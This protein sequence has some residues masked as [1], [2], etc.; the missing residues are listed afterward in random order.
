MGVVQVTGTE[1]K[2]PQNPIDLSNFTLPASCPGPTSP[3][4]KPSTS[5]GN[6]IGLVILLVPIVMAI[7]LVAGGAYFWYSSQSI[8][9]QAL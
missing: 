6:L 2:L 9:F 1:S 7:A 4:P 3:R 8:S 5:M